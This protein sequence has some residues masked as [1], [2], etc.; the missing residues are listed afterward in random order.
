MFRWIS[1]WVKPTPTLNALGSRSSVLFVVLFIRSCAYTPFAK[2]ANANKGNFVHSFTIFLNYSFGRVLFLFN[3][4]FIRIIKTLVQ[5]FTIFMSA[6]SKFKHRN[7]YSQFSIIK[8]RTVALEYST[9]IPF[10]LVLSRSHMKQHFPLKMHN[11]K[12]IYSSRVGSL[13]VL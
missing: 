9:L 4:D 10:P 11:E 5:H 7:C 13:S 1:F 2:N 3:F 6:K 8:S 12:R